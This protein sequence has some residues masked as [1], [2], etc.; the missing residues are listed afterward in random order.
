MS[1][2]NLSKFLSLVLRHKPEALGFSLDKEGW[3]SVA[4]LMEK[5]QQKGMDVD[6]KQLQ[7][8]VA[9]NDKQ[10]FS[11]SA[12]GTKI[13]ANQ[14]HSLPIELGLEPVTPPAT[15]YHGTAIQ[16]ISSILKNG[17]ERRKRQHVHLSQDAETARKVG[18]RHGKPVILMI[19]SEQM[20]RE[21]HLF[22]HSAN[23]VW[24]TEAAPPKFIELKDGN[25]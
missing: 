11:F 1:H 14:G 4:E 7:K 18:Q 23:G 15:L 17:L 19:R 3:A 9:T 5:M 6:L 12:D 16:N 21:G 8:V 13:R 25:Q 20:H 24:L 10:R 22:Y 2:K